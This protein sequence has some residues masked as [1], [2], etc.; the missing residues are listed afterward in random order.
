M[1]PS[2]DEWLKC[3]TGK[4]SARLN[5]DGS[6]RLFIGKDVAITLQLSEDSSRLM[7]MSDLLRLDNLSPEILQEV[8]E[9]NLRFDL[10][11]GMTVALEKASSTLIVFYQCAP[12]S[13]NLNTFRHMLE[14]VAKNVLL[15]RE[16]LNGVVQRSSV[17]VSAQNH[18][19]SQGVFV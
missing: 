19:L 10:T 8:A 5:P 12:G 13:L 6:Y 4:E 9:I 14:T 3:L 17:S 7:V 1:W 18:E 11:S 2:L 16:F 15:I